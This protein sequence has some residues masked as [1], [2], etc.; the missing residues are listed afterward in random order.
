MTID[1][2]K[3]G[4]KL[5]DEK[6]NRNRLITERSDSCYRDKQLVL[7]KKNAMALFGA[8]L[9]QASSGHTYKVKLQNPRITTQRLYK[10]LEIANRECGTEASFVTY[11]KGQLIRL[12]G[13]V[14]VEL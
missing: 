2:K 1:R 11:D 13:C 3:L 10:Y 5:H 9:L 6:M 12:N 4:Q 8:L 14:M 7:Q